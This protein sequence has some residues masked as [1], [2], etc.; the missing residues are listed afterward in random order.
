MRCVL[1]KADM[2]VTEKQVELIAFLLTYEGR[3]DMLGGPGLSKA[4]LEIWIPGSHRRALRLRAK[5]LLRYNEKRKRW[6]VQKWL[7]AVTRWPF[8]GVT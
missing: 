5:G 3:S 8:E 4:E 7:H 6:R 2:L 1:G